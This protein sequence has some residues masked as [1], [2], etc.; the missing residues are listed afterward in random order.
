MKRGNSFLISSGKIPSAQQ[1]W[2][3]YFNATNHHILPIGNPRL[4]GGCGDSQSRSR[5]QKERIART[6]RIFEHCCSARLGVLV[7]LSE[8]ASRRSASIRRFPLT[9]QIFMSNPPSG[10]RSGPPGAGDGGGGGGRR[11]GNPHRQSLRPQATGPK[12]LIK[13]M[14]LWS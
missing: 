14:L 9:S 10:D 5:T 3:Q 7:L 4:T 6:S 1:I 2:F 13:A 8:R 12:T 11:P